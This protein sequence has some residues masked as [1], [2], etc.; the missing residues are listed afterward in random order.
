MCVGP[1]K[2]KLALYIFHLQYERRIHNT[3]VKGT[4]PHETD[5]CERFLHM[6]PDYTDTVRSCASKT[7]KF[8]NCLP[9]RK[10]SPVGL[11][12]FY[13]HFSMY[14]VKNMVANIVAKYTGLYTALIH[15]SVNSQHDVY[16]VYPYL[17]H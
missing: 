15:S 14:Y 2:A 3:M 10:S 8:L 6:L 11:S 4:K 7:V 9:C 12:G 16:S 13:W 5:C 17:A 1:K